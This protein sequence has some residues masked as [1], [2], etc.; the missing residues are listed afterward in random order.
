MLMPTGVNNRSGLKVLKMLA[1]VGLLKRVARPD[2]GAWERPTPG[3][4]NRPPRVCRKTS[5]GVT[6]GLV[7]KLLPPPSQL[8][9]RRPVGSVGA[10]PLFGSPRAARN[11]STVVCIEMWVWSS[12]L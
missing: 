9:S 8:I 2:G 1:Y 12:V 6:G 4:V 10:L 5:N 7:V 11:A 3:V